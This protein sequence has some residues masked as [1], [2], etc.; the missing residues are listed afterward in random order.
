MKQF[1]AVFTILTMVAG[2]AIAQDTATSRDKTR[3]G[4]AIGAALLSMTAGTGTN[5][6]LPTNYQL[7]LGTSLV[8]ANPDHSKEDLCFKD[9]Q[10]HF[11]R[12]SSSQRV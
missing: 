11:S 10:Q 4:A 12:S 2:S 9:F 1:I 6:Q 5:H 8:L 7:H 3:R